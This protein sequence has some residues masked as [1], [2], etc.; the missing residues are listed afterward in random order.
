[1]ISKVQLINPSIAAIL[2]LDNHIQMQYEIISKQLT[3]LRDEVGPGERVV[4]LEL[5]QSINATQDRAADKMAQTWWRIAGYTTVDKDMVFQLELKRLSNEIK[6]IQ[7][8][9]KATQTTDYQVKLAKEHDRL[10]KAYTSLLT[11]Y[12]RLKL[13]R[14]RKDIRDKQERIDRL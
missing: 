10:Q 7:E 4:F 12:E 1:L 5:P 11:K 14:V 9:I 2:R 3:L 8:K 13:E 6:V